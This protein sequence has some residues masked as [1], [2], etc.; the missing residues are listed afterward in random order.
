MFK[1]WKYLILITVIFIAGCIETDIYLPAFTDMMAYFSISEEQIQGLLT[2]NF[3]G[4]CVSGLF[5]GPVSDAIGRRKPLMFAL[6]I[7]FVGSVITLIAHDFTMMLVGRVLQGL[8]T[9]G[10]FTLGTAVIFDAYSEEKAIQALNRIN[11]IIPFIMAAAPMLGGYLNLT[12]GFRSN[13]LAIAICVL[14]SLLICSFF[15]QETL[16]KDKRVPLDI[17]K[18][19]SDFKTVS[20]S[21]PFWQ[22]VLIV[23]LGFAAYLTFLSGISVLFVIELG[24]TKQMLPFFQASLL[25]AWLAANLIFV[26]AMNKMGVVWVKKIGTWLIFISGVGLFAGVLYDSL[27]PYIPTFFMMLFAWGCNW[28]QGI[29]FPEGMAIFPDIKGVT[30]SFLSSARLLFTA[31]VVGLA[32]VL[33]DGTIY[34]IAWVVC[35]I[36]AVVLVNI[37]LYERNRVGSPDKVAHD[38]IIEMI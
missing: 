4:V 36:I 30:S 21:A 10:C 16:P 37:I 32:S 28:V 26:T 2:W 9:G 6:G 12:F 35:S 24:V 17:K 38:Q 19:L 33:Y 25:G 15:Y 31:I 22:M 11:T 8:G 29:Y 27:N 13:F 3:I 18:I 1:E 20:S 5:Y 23:S 34:P 14:L 7:F